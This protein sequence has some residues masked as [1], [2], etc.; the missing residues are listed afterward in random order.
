MPI[1]FRSTGLVGGPDFFVTRGGRGLGVVS[2]SVTVAV[3]ERPDGL[4]LIDTGWSRRT[5]A[6]PEEHPG[7]LAKLLLAMKVKPEDAMASQLL[8]LGYNPGDVK[9]LIATHLHIDHAGAADDF[10]QAT[11]HASAREWAIARTLGRLRGYDAA[12]FSRPRTASHV[13]SGPP[14]LG[15]PASHDLF[16]DDSV[17]LLD[18]RGHTQG[19]LAVAVRLHD[20]WALHA[21]DAA[22]FARDFRHDRALPLSPYQRLQSHDLYAQRA[23]YGHLRAAETE[24]DARVVP[25]HDLKV[26]ES[27]PQSAEKA[28]ACAWDKKKRKGR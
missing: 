28:W 13:L 9:H 21:G 5:C 10:A 1:L 17:L 12:L 14:R 20:G 4:V 8:S 18:A 15:F 19:S 3:V 22:M 11:L 25:A 23:S 2:M 27:L 24:H 7:R 6:W 16:G 26:F